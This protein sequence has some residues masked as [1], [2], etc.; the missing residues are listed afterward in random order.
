MHIQ[1]V[2]GVLQVLLA[3]EVDLKHPSETWKEDSGFRNRVDKV[4]EIYTKMRAWNISRAMIDGANAALIRDLK[5]RH[6]ERTDYE[7]LTEQELSGCTIKPIPFNKYHKEMLGHAQLLMQKGL[8]AISPRFTKLIDSCRTAT[9]KDGALDKEST[10]Y[11][12]CFD[13]FRLALFN[14]KLDKRRRD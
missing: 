14:F 13:D 10:L 6:R 11:D 2:D 9:S 12:N 8:V 3:D 7:N 5:L 1:Q 4:Q